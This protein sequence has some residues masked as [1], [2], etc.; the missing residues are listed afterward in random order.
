MTAIKRIF[1][2]LMAFTLILSLFPTALA[3]DEDDEAVYVL[4]YGVTD[5]GYTGP[6]KQYFSPYLVDYNYD[7]AF[8]RL[9]QIFI[10]S[11][12]NTVSGEVIPTYC[13]DILINAKVGSKYRRLNLENSTFAAGSAGKL[14]AILKNGFY[15][16]EREGETEE[17][18]ASRVKNNVLALGAACG[19]P[20]LT[21]GE[22][23]S[24]T[25]LAIWQ[26][27]HGSL[28][29]YTD[30][31]SSVYTFTNARSAYEHYDLCNEERANGHY[32]ISNSKI[33]EESK[34]YISGRIK[35]VFNYLLSLDPLATTNPAVSASS[36]I[37][38]SPPAVTVK[39][40]GTCDISV[41]TTV[42][43]SMED[44]DYLTLT[45]DLDNT[46][47]ESVSLHD[48]KQERT[49]T[50]SGVPAELADEEVHLT[51]Q[52]VQ[53]ASEVFMYDANGDRGES[54]TMIGMDDS[55]MPV[56]ARV[57]AAEERVLNFHKT[58]KVAEGSNGVG[59]YPL[60][61]ISFDLYY[62][63]SMEDYLAVNVIL[64]E[65]EDYDYSALEPIH[66]VITDQ[67]GRA[68]VNF[69][70]HGLPDGAYLVVEREHPAIQKPI[71]P[72]YIIMPSRVDDSGYIYEFTAE[73]KND[74]KGGIRIE[75]DVISLGK[76]ESTVD[77]AAK[78]TWIISASIPEDIV[79]GKAYEISDTLDPRLDYEGNLKAQLETAAGEEVLLT[80][81]ADADYTLTVDDQDSLSEGSPSDSF[82]L[83][84][85]PGAMVKLS[86]ALKDKSYDEYMLRIYFDAKIN[87][88]AEMG[89]EIPN[90]A[91]M[92]YVN[93]VNFKFYAKSDRPVVY[94][95]GVTLKKVDSSNHDILLSGAEFEVYRNATES[96]VAAGEGLVTFDGIAAPMVKVPFFNNAKMEGGQVTTA[97]S[98]E[99]GKVEI[100]GLAYGS[101]YLLETKSPVGYNLSEGVKKITINS[102]SHMDENVVIVENISGLVLPSTGGI[103]TH[104]FT[105]AGIFLTS[106]AVVLLF[107]LKRKEHSTAA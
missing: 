16:T 103:G 70:H 88:N 9:H 58:T 20:D 105:A 40:D 42:D 14:R 18:H 37:R 95:G 91:T 7:S 104:I 60:E 11:L 64:P 106:A 97:T 51:I 38:V 41:T 34:A 90:E 31:V 96:E 87:G 43:V 69:T 102:T 12:Y 79:G 86:D 85:T 30:Y 98:D 65:S 54:Q 29:E 3:A 83:E 59:S 23:I 77:A 44:G 84:L 50:I 27:A 101:Y 53:T 13:T 21:L 56:Y 71:D 76:D 28:L 35:T 10:F 62:V 15:V 2:L 39:E 68:S 47:T 107:L 24:G 1:V 80:L 52:G 55:P 49:L 36:F 6:D 66:T 78:H 75:K 48:G 63:A 67:D 94:T 17:E 82:R 26:A 89:E 22:A 99:N 74:V 57:R 19:I 92:S 72:F 73:P 4:H 45:A 81:A 61:G 8:H 25:Q 100:Y 33:T 46:Y 32:T 5:D 93:S